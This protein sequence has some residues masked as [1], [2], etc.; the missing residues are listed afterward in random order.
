MK[1]KLTFYLCAC[2]GEAIAV[3][4]PDQLDC[5]IGL[6][7]WRRG[8]YS[9]PWRYRLQHMWYILRYGHPYVEDVLLSPSDAYGLTERLLDFADMSQEIEK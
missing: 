8:S 2:G 5:S 1:E 4:E 3:G 9:L 7:M 6:S